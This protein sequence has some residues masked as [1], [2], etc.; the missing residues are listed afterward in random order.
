MEG[1]TAKALH[2]I[3]LPADRAPGWPRGRLFTRRGHDW[4]NRYPAIAAAAITLRAT[5]F[6]LD[7]EA[8][9]CGRL[10]NI[11]AST[12]RSPPDRHHRL[13]RHPAYRRQATT[14]PRPPRQVPNKPPMAPRHPASKHTA[15]YCSLFA[16]LPATR[17]TRCQN[18]ERTQLTNTLD[19]AC[20]CAA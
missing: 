4:T 3:R 10:K 5:C 2:R 14:P 11:S 6:T 12:K 17:E 15:K 7:G 1:S 8:A 16:E 18:T 9:V 13:R 20:V 19:S